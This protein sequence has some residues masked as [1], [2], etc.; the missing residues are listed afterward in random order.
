VEFFRELFSTSSAVDALELVDMIRATFLSFFLS[1]II[2]YIYRATHQGP[3]YSQSTVHTMTIMTVVVSLIMMVI[4][5]NIARA[6]SL[7]GALSIIR[8]RNAV[9][10]SRDVAFYFLSMGVG[11]ACGTGF[12]AIAM[13]FTVIVCAMI[14]FMARFQVGG[15]PVVEVLLRVT[16]GESVEY[17]SAFN[18]A[19]YK[20]LENSDLLTVDSDGSGQLELLYTITLR[21][22]DRE[23]ALLADLRRVDDSVR[24]QLIHGHSAVSL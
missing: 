24:A 18:E 11:M 9:K 14:Y 17:Q 15:K 23:Q 4:G 7:V 16:A 12:H 6:F 13:V 3:S 8:F 20:H 5:T 22:G 2:G 21:K 10:E 19:F 1:L